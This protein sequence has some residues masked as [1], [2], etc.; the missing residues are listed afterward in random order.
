MDTNRK[1]QIYRKYVNII[2]STKFG[3]QVKVIEVKAGSMP[4]INVL[5]YR[6]GPVD[7]KIVYNTWRSN[8]RRPQQV[9]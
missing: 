1:I 9:S 4:H 2:V 6:G 5:L 7:H 3:N 8:D